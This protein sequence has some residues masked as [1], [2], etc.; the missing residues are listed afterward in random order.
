MW[1][2]KYQ[3]DSCLHN[4]SCLQKVPAGPRNTGQKTCQPRLHATKYLKSIKYYN[5]NN[6]RDKLYVKPSWKVTVSKTR[7]C[8]YQYPSVKVLTRNIFCSFV[9]GDWHAISYI[10][11]KLNKGEEDSNFLYI[12]HTTWSMAMNSDVFKNYSLTQTGRMERE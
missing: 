6:K 7:D 8:K 4:C 3:C 5:N 9:W 12:W 11:A 2:V 1:P 10:H